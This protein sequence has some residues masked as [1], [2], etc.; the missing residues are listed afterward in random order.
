MIFLTHLR[1]LTIDGNPA[2]SII[3][4][5][6]S[7]PTGAS[8]FLKFSYNNRESPFLAYLPKTSPNLG[9]LACITAVS[10]GFGDPKC[11]QLNGPSGCIR[12]SARWVE[13]EWLPSYTVDRQIFRS[14]GAPIFSTIQMLSISEYGHSPPA[15]STTCPVFE[16][17][18]S[19]SNL[20]T[21]VLDGCNGLPFF[22][23]LDPEKVPHKLVLCPNLEKIGFFRDRMWQPEYFDCT[24]ELI[25]MTKNRDSK[26]A[27]ILSMMITGHRA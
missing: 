24:E 26:G 19:A 25:N 18:S 14:F 8:L 13:E 7:I 5:H 16:T 23:A 6:L 2:P 9:N 10:L 15:E 21:L 22:H 3:L 1:K 17:L 20:R 4:N 12:V 27:K 11:A